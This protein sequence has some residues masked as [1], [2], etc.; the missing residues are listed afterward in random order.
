MGLDLRLQESM[1]DGELSARP[2]A[3]KPLAGSSAAAFLSADGELQEI[4]D[5]HFIRGLTREI[6]IRCF[7]VIAR[8]FLK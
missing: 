1:V 7:S 8:I 5:G 2:A 3:V 4:P 6:E